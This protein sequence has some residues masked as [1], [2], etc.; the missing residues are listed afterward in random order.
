MPITEETMTAVEMVKTARDVS[1]I[2]TFTDLYRA[3]SED[4]PDMKS[5]KLVMKELGYS[6]QSEVTETPAECYLKI[7][8]AR[9]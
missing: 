2:K 6:A 3:C 5:S 7:K 4:F 8:T 1:A 9:G